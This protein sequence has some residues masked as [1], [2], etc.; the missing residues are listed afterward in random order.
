MNTKTILL[1]IVIPCYNCSK[2]IEECVASI[3][4]ETEENSLSYEIICVNDGSTDSTLSLLKVI[5]SRNPNI[6]IFSQENAGPSAARNNGV[7]HSSGEFVAFCDSD[8]KWLPKKLEKQITYLK[9]HADVDFVCAKYGRGKV[10]RT[11]KI[12]YLEEIFHNFFSPQTALLRRCVFDNYYFPENQKY[13]EDMH[14]LLDVMQ[15]HICV[16]MALRSTVPVFEKR[17]FGESGLSARLWEMERG[18]LSNIHYARKINKISIL[19]FVLAILWSFTKFLRRC[20]ISFVGK[21]I[22]K[23]NISYGRKFK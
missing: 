6:K 20:G 19:I 10:G 5:A 23:K 1:S 8:D 15:S 14:F 13:S 17:F 22:S 3:V 21:L 4:S 2:T 18:E 9:E 16:Y 12:T 7:K 11:Q